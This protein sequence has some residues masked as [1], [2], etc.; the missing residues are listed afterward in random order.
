MCIGQ[1][2]PFEA[3]FFIIIGDGE[4]EVQRREHCSSSSGQCVRLLHVEVRCGVLGSLLSCLAREQWGTLEPCD[5][6]WE[7]GV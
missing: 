7:G 4:T 2:L 5:A 1:A 3:F 6:I